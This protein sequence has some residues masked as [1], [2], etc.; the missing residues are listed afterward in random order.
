M[1]NIIIYVPFNSY[2]PRLYLSDCDT[3]VVVV[4]VHV[5]WVL[6]SSST[7]GPLTILTLVTPS[8][9]RPTSVWCMQTYTL[10]LFHIKMST[11]KVCI[12]GYVLI[13][14][15]W[16]Q[17]FLNSPAQENSWNQINRFHEFFFD[18]IPF[19]A[20]SKMAKNQFLN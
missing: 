9:T 11:F 15:C 18:Q 16:A 4:R 14:W 8:R 2:Y 19:F 10:V 7:V 1:A 17:I 5:F 20:I 3:C 6:M 13:D 12:A